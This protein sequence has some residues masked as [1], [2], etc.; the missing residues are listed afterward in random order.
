VFD[1]FVKPSVGQWTSN[2]FDELVKPSYG[3]WTSNV[4]DE[5]VKP[6]FWAMD[7]LTCLKMC[8]ANVFGEEFKSWLVK[9]QLCILVYEL[10]I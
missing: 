6:C 1:E 3:R 9:A 2:V 4:V 5:F 8:E 10:T 7:N